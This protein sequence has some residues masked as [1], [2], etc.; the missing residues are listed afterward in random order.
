M[1]NLLKKKP[2]KNQYITTTKGTQTIVTH[3]HN[4]KI[5]ATYKC[6]IENLQD[7]D[8]LVKFENIIKLI[9]KTNDSK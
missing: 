1:L 5:V 2:N 4:N 6:N 3:F 7:I 9:N 8:L